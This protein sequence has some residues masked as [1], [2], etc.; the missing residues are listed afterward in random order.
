MVTVD[1]GPLEHGPRFDELVKLFVTDEPIVDSLD[2]PWARC[3]CSCTDAKQR[4]WEDFANPCDDRSF[5]Y[6]G[7]AGEDDE[8]PPGRF[9]CLPILIGLKPQPECSL[10]A[11]TEKPQSLS[12]GDPGFVKYRRQFG[13][14]DSPE[15]HEEFHHSET[16]L[17]AVGIL[18]GR[19]R[20]VSSVTNA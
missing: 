17:G 14:S 16:T 9:G 1:G 4:G 13:L 7:W 3:S 10:L 15:R 8:L 5:P 18:P 12:V 11:D 2:F 20:Y 19:L 6:C